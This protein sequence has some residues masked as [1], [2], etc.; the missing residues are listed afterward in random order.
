MSTNK[1]TLAANMT[2]VSESADKTST[3]WSS[4]EQAI[5]SSSSS[6]SSSDLKTTDR[7]DDASV[8]QEKG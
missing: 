1:T 8:R 4:S 5:V 6:S 7:E 3:A 2:G